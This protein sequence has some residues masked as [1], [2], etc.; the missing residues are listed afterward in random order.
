MKSLKKQ[1]GGN[2][3][4]SLKIQPI[5]F[6][7]D[8]NLS[9]VQLLAIRYLSR[10]R[11][12]NKGEDLQKAMHILE[13]IEDKQPSLTICNYKNTTAYCDQFSNRPEAGIIYYILQG[14]IGLAKLELS[15]IIDYL[16]EDL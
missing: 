10:F 4:K 3:Y 14:D 2:H 1:V 12:K 5:E 11:T 15:N 9:A 16:S 6:A 13:I 7:I 8:N